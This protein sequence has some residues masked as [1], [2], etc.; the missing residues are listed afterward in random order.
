M[1]LGSYADLSLADARKTAK[2]LQA[3]V[4]VGLDVAAEKPERKQ[5]AVAKI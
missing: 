3:R 1:R 2:E 4:A 5:E